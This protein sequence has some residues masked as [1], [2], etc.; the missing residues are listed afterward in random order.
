MANPLENGFVSKAQEEYFKRENPK[1]W[2][3]VVRK[4]GS[5]GSAKHQKHLNKYKR[6]R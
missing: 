5:Y 1:L 2:R 3:L 6:G 4:F